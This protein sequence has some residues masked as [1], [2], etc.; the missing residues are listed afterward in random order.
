MLLLNTMFT[1]LPSLFILCLSINTQVNH[2]IEMQQYIYEFQQYTYT[3]VGVR[4]DG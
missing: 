1:S 3:F 4:G 2:L